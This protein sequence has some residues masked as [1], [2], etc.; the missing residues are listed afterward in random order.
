MENFFKIKKPLYVLYYYWKECDTMI[1]DD[2]KKIPN[3]IISEIISNRYKTWKQQS[4]KEGGYFVVFI[5]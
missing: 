1:S 4:L 2:K 3:K 5:S